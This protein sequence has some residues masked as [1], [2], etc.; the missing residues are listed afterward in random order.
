MPEKCI[1]LCYYFCGPTLGIMCPRDTACY[2]TFDER[3]GG[4]VAAV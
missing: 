2:M 3:S 1:N 4:N